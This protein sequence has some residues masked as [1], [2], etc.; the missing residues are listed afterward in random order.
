MASLAAKD[1]TSPCASASAVA[2]F[3]LSA[4]NS[5]SFDGGGIPARCDLD[6]VLVPH[7]VEI[8][9]QARILKVFGRV[10]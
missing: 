5:C 9:V 8:V 7:S 4:D 2:A 10:V 3:C 6:R 1:L